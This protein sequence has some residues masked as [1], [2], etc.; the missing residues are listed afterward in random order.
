MIR[1]SQEKFQK[2]SLYLKVIFATA[3]LQK[4]TKKYL[5]KAI[6]KEIMCK[7]AQKMVST[8]I[9]LLDLGIRV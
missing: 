6:A 1:H 4:S 3:S 9:E 7:G 5:R 2:T 8:I